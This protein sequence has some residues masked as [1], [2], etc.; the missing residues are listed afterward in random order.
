MHIT[1]E[2]LRWARPVVGNVPC[3]YVVS[4][5]GEGQSR[6][7]V[8]FETETAN[9]L[10]RLAAAPLAWI[11]LVMIRKQFLTIKA[12]AERDQQRAERAN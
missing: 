11:D 6:L 10:R 9:P 5:R 3:T 7:V 12:Y 8:R 1:S 2:V 4:P